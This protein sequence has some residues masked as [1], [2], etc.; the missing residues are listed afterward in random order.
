MLITFGGHG[1]SKC[2]EKLSDV[3]VGGL[4]M[5][6]LE[7]VQ[8]QLPPEFIRSEMRVRKRDPVGMEGRISTETEDTTW[9][10]FLGKYENEVEIALKKLERFIVDGNQVNEGYIKA[11]VA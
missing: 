11:N 2:A 1:G 4:K 10:E 8:I 6:L 9:P 3:L 7:T 5:Q